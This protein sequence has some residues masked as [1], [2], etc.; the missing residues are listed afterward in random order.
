MKKFWLLMISILGLSGCS[1]IDNRSSSIEITGSEVSGVTSDVIVTE[2]TVSSSFTLKD[3][4]NNSITP[5]NNVY[6]ITGSGTYTASGKLEN[7]QIYVN[8]PSN[9]VELVLE[10]VS[11]S[12]SSVSPIFVY[13][14]SDFTL[15]VKNET[16]N[17]IYDNR[18]T[19]YS[20]TTSDTVGTSAVFVRNGDLKIN[21]KGTLSVTSVAN[22]GIHGKDNVTVKNTTMLIKAVNNGI[23]GNDKVSIEENP[24]IS[25]IAGNNGIITSNSDLGDSVQ[26]G[27][28][29]IYG[30]SL[31]INS[32]GDGIDAAYAVVINSS[33]DSE[34][35]RYTPSL[36]IYTNKYSSYTLSSVIS[37]PNNLN[38][39]G[40][41]PGGGGGGFGGGT[42]AEKADDSAKAIKA[43][44]S[45]TI[46]A[47]EI[48]TYTYDDGLHTNSDTMENGKKGSANIKI[49]G[50]SLKMKA[51]DDAIH[52]DG[53]L[54]IG[55]GTIYISES[56]EGIEGN[57]V[58]IT[59]GDTTVFANDDGVNASSL[60]NIS[61]GRL[62]VTVNPN[63][64][65]DG[66]DSNGT[67]TI[68]GGT[69]ITRGPNSEM[70]APLDA[71]GTMKMSGGT[72]VVCGYAPRKLTATGLTKTSSTNGLS[73]GNHTVTI[74]TITINYSNTYSYKGNTTVY[75]NATATIS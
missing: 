63:G 14:V 29:Y 66:I 4:N 30:G 64:D 10:D 35:T 75:A 31:T 54:T 53:T 56:H 20:T 48:F 37:N 71:D 2:D 61:G 13:D 3:S 40:P 22:S 24:N 17:Y 70:A 26:H 45:I 39:G 59:G 46:D 5:T 60:I 47:G 69:I 67:I 12:N 44:E 9:E 55:G 52:A 68:T 21:G 62:D 58:I 15:K 16:T 51:S 73:I 38:A 11:I 65:T 18:T 43:V 33:T 72:L 32:Y 74:G 42:S 19:D 27:Y 50:G 23:K 36:D 41:P 8:S 7:G 28:I 49:S 1:I 57:N 6:K 25:I 34:G